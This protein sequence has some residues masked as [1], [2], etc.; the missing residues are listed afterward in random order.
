MKSTVT[1]FA[2][3]GLRGRSSLRSTRSALC[4]VTAVLCAH[5][6]KGESPL[7]LRAPPLGSGGSIGSAGSGSSLRPTESVESSA[8][9]GW[10]RMTASN[11]KTLVSW[12][13]D[14]GLKD[15]LRV[16]NE[17]FRLCSLE[18]GEHC[19]PE[20]PTPRSGICSA[21]YRD[22]SGWTACLDW[23]HDRPKV[24]QVE[25]LVRAQIPVTCEMI[26]A[27]QLGRP[28][29]TLDGPRPKDDWLG[30]L[31]TLRDYG[32][33][34]QQKRPWTRGEDAITDIWIHSAQFID[35]NEG[36][37]RR[38]EHLRTEAGL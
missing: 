37:A 38:L 34:V 17:S 7:E 11:L 31:C 28:W 27:S 32:I 25:F 20:N 35:L 10:P 8:A 3:C 18:R 24:S 9:A 12:A 23:Q 4:A 19:G 36:A 26:G 33:V 16:A 2:W 13:L 29:G 21:A 6:D 1:S 30:R 14:R 22:P 15:P 5:C